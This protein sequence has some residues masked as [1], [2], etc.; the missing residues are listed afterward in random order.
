[1]KRNTERSPN[2]GAQ[3]GTFAFLTRTR[4]SAKDGGESPCAFVRIVNSV[5]RERV[6][7]KE[8]KRITNNSQRNAKLVRYVVG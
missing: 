4:I 3:E 8:E 1:M 2:N 7:V 5:L 6:S